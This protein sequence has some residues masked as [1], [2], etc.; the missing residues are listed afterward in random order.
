MS[1]CLN[2]NLLKTFNEKL[3]SGE[4]DPKKLRDMSP[5]D[6]HKFF[7]SFLGENNANWVNASFESKL[8]L[9]NQEEGL[10]SWAEKTGASKQAKA[11]IISRIERL[12][13]VLNPADK[14]T[15]FQDL[16]AQK[17]GATITMSEA[18]RV[19]ELAKGVSDASKIRSDNGVPTLD[20]WEKRAEMD[21][22]FKS[23]NP[24]D[25]LRVLT[26]VIGRGNMLFHIPGIVVKSASEIVQGALQAFEKRAGSLF[27]GQ[28]MKGANGDYAI[29]LVKD[30]TKIFEKSGYSPA[31][32]MDLGQGRNWLG[33]QAT[34]SEGKGPLR[35]I[36]RF[37]EKYVFHTAYGRPADLAANLSFADTANIYS[38]QMAEKLLPGGTKAEIKAKALEIFK[39]ASGFEAQ[40]PEAQ[41][42]R[43]QAQVDALSASFQNIGKASKLAITLRSA[44]NEATGN[45][46]V[47]DQLMPIV[48]TPANVIET[49][50]D[51]AGIAAIKGAKALGFDGWNKL[52][53]AFKKFEAG[54]KA[55]MQ[56]AVRLFV[57]AGM[58]AA[59]AAVIVSKINPDDFVGGYD[60]LA[61]NE[62]ALA[63]VRNAPFN[64]VK[65]GGSWES[66]GFFG[67]LMPAIVAGLYAKKYGTA[68]YPFGAASEIGDLPGLSQVKDMVE[69]VTNLIKA[70]DAGKL[71]QASFDY[72]TGYIRARAIPSFVKEI[73]S[74][75]DPSQRVTEHDQLSKV[76]ATTPGVSKGLPEKLD[77]TTGKPMSNENFLSSVIFG[78]RVKTANENKLINEIAR[79][80]GVGQAPTI[81]DLESSGSKRIQELKAQIGDQ[82][83]QEAVKNFGETFG[84][85]ATHKIQNPN[86]IKAT[87]E[88]KKKIIN[89]LREETINHLM[90]RYHYRKPVK[91]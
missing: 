72:A 86:Y 14:K 84:N 52:P 1:D 5:E 90:I 4:I 8:L 83:F 2:P 53:E 50:L 48:R 59:L 35:A 16:A 41:F 67:P 18:A 88:D 51:Y 13:K 19:S 74:G 79:L 28:T 9:K 66:L 80:N 39:E 85:K 7:A 62:K 30:N 44:V 69:G 87:D 71:G 64:S 21:D 76:R 60:N 32:M 36:G 23:L 54:D 43:A 56:N 34:H 24:T 31:T 57:R 37:M 10:I 6:R 15:F 26:S 63:G 89:N 3:A 29:Q 55:P 61:G 47:G 25:N 68:A 22:Y 17:L 82:K 70:H 38:T 33:E 11:D 75:I 73:A 77:P 46:R 45:L 40:S 81:T 91:K 78:N 12:D 42:V 58:G 49:G 20:Y 27:T 65:I